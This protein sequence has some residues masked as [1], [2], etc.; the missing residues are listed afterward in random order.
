MSADGGDDSRIITQND[1]SVNYTEWLKSDV[2]GSD[3]FYEYVDSLDLP[4]EADILPMLSDGTFSVQ[5]KSELLD[6][7]ADITELQ[8]LV[9]FDALFGDSSGNSRQ[10]RQGGTQERFYVSDVTIPEPN[11]APTASAIQ[12]LATETLSTYDDDHVIT[13]R[14]LTR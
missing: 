14:D 5:L 8:G 12:D 3:E 7:V 4:N 11:E 9:D 1:F 13:N 2:F 10:D 6:G